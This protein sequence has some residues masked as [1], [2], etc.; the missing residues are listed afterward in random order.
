MVKPCPGCGAT[1]VPEARFCRLCGTPLKVAGGREGEAPVS[2]KA[3]TIPLTGE[4]RS[5]D[6]LGQD[7]PRRPAPN[8]SRVGRAEMDKL[9]RSASADVK[10]SGDGGA[11]K[12]GAQT[13]TLVSDKLATESGPKA[14]ASTPASS[15]TSSRRRWQVAAVALLCVALVAGVL[16]FILS[17]RSGSTAEDGSSPISIS[18]QQ[19]L[20]SEKLAEAETL[21]A[22]GEFNRAI[23]VLRAAAKLSPGNAEV[24]MRLGNALERTGARDEAI[25]EYRAAAESNQANEAAWRALASAQFEEKLYSDAADSYRRLAELTGELDEETQLNYAEA[26]RLAGRVDEARVAYQRIYNS[27]LPDVAR[28]ARTRLAELGPA[29]GAPAANTN[30]PRPRAEQR[31][32][33]EERPAEIASASPISTP[34]P[35]VVPT[36]TPAPAA[37]PD[38]VEPRV[39]YDSYFF[40][41]VNIVNGR[42]PKQI[43]RAELL[44][45]LALFQ[46][47]ALG[48]THRGE[49]QRY[50]ARLGKEYDRRRKQG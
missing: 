4:P 44:H 39:D 8:T 29:P 38:N 22:S 6:G 2:P 16:A 20:V 47:A 40:Q 26:L 18:D 27:A 42:E 50:A 17:R 13:T 28:A 46:K 5:T 49:A 14:A 37:T 7:E 41:A 15:N 30:E 31:E 10:P 33:Q 12:S 36:R 32:P 21:L 11:Q 43:E 9:L 48:G 25:A 23:T 3:Q 19:Q 1:T 24:R 45:A 35:L 34:P